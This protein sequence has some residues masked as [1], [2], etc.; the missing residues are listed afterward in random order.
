MERKFLYYAAR[1]PCYA[2]RLYA[3]LAT[4][5]STGNRKRGDRMP[6]GQHSTLAP[7]SSM[8]LLL[9]APPLESRRSVPV[10]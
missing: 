8:A 10:F 7:H 1:R 6:P 2:V 3:L 5:H 9:L 4:T